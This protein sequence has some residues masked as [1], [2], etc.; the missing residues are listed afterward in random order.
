VYLYRDL[1]AIDPLERMTDPNPKDG[2]PLRVPHD[3]KL[4]EKLQT[5][6]HQA[7]QVGDVEVTPLGV[8]RDHGDL[9]LRLRFR[10]LSEDVTFNPFPASFSHFLREWRN[11]V[12]PYTYLQVGEQR[13]YGGD[14]EWWQGPPGHEERRADG[15]LAP[16]GEM[17]ALLRTDFRDRELVKKVSEVN[18]PLLWRVH[19]RRGFVEV[20]GQ[21]VS[22]TA[23]VGVRFTKDDVQPEN[24]GKP[25]F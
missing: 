8:A 17:I 15:N 11:P 5:S 14:P 20:R 7:L 6:M 25:L 22:A 10:N 4:P 9:V 12:W 18:E 21:E 23:V 13:I 19:V 24:A 16:G 2:G 1:Q 3:R